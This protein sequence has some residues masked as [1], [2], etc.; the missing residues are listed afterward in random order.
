MSIE[1]NK[2]VI[3]KGWESFSKRDLDGIAAIYHDDVVYHGAADEEIRGRD[4]LIAWVNDYLTAFP[5]IDAHVEDQIAEG[6][7]VFSRVRTV[8]TNTGPLMGKAPTGRRVEL[9]WMTAHRFRDGKVAEEWELFD[10]MDMLS[11]LGHL[12][13]PG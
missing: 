13:A 1:S 11:Q 9:R 6:D 8:G 10:R 5:D 7:R 4:V 12:P 2:E 3:R